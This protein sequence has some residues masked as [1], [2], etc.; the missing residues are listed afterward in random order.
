M[1]PSVSRCAHYSDESLHIVAAKR[2]STREDSG[3]QS[4]TRQARRQAN[5]VHGNSTIRL[6]L[7]E[8]IV[9]SRLVLLLLLAFESVQ[10]S[11]VISLTS[12]SRVNIKRVQGIYFVFTAL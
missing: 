11:S 5:N 10:S 9:F 12:S 3:T 2:S 8:A 1:S 6:A 4:Q 7:V